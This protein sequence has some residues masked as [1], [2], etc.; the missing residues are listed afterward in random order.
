MCIRDSIYTLSGKVTHEHYTPMRLLAFDFAYDQNVFDC[1][2]QFMYGPAL[3][4]CP[5][6]EAGAT[7][8]SVYLPQG[9]TWVDFWTGAIYQ[10]GTTIRCV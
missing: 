5:V 6:L 8:R 3:L 10:G 7:S 1:K 2:D 9:C 4:V